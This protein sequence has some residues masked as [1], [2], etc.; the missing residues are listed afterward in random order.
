MKAKDYVKFLLP[1]EVYLIFMVIYLINLDKLNKILLSQYKDNS[2]SLLLYNDG[3]PIKYFCIA[4]F[5][6]IVGGYIIFRRFNRIRFEELDF[7]EI[8]ASIIALLLMLFL[9]V[10]LWVFINNPILR[11]I[12]A[13]IMVGASVIYAYS[14]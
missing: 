7:G 13:A 2:I 10:L 3:K 11:M 14:N 8:I 4:L 1:E 9:L 5:L 6:L 12:F